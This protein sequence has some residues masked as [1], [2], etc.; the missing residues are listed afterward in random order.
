MAVTFQYQRR[1]GHLHRLPAGA[2]LAALFA[3]VLV[4]MTLPVQALAGCAAA[5]SLALIAA[6]WTAEEFLAD[7]R[8][9]LFH[10][11]PV[12]IAGVIGALLALPGISALSFRILLPDITTLRSICRNVSVSLFAA[13]VFRTTTSI[14]VKETLCAL[15]LRIRAALKKRLPALRIDAAQTPLATALALTL[16]FI[17]ETA[18]RWNSLSRSWRARGGRGGL[19]K[20]RVLLFSLLTLSLYAASQKAKA[21]SARGILP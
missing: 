20:M 14:E 8:P 15:E 19:Q 3:A 6:G 11:L 7:T 5:A 12:Y 17:P 9:A 21:L 13:L 16:C 18:E 10:A 2:K 4:I 1:L